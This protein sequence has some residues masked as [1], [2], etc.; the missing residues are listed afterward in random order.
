MVSRLRALSFIHFLYF[1][2][3]YLYPDYGLAAVTEASKIP[4]KEICR[5]G[6]VSPTD[7]MDWVYD[8]FGVKRKCTGTDPNRQIAL[9]T[10]PD[11]DTKLCA[12]ILQAQNLTGL[13]ISQSSKSYS[14]ARVT[15]DTPANR[16]LFLRGKLSVQCVVVAPAEGE[17]NSEKVPGAKS[18]LIQDSLP[19][20]FQLRIRDSQDNLRHDQGTAGFKKAG[21]AKFSIDRDTLAGTTE[22]YTKGVIGLDTG[23]RF[24]GDHTF[25]LTPYFTGERKTNT[26]PGTSGDIDKIGGGLIADFDY[27]PRN[28]PLHFGLSIDPQFLTDSIGKTRIWGGNLRL[29]PAVIFPGNNI[30]PGGRRTVGPITYDLDL[31]FLG[32][33]SNVVDNGGRP[34]LSLSTNYAYGGP[35][36][37]L[38][39]AGADDTWLDRF[40]MAFSYYNLY[41]YTGTY[42]RIEMF[43][44]ELKYALDTAG[45]F[46]LAL[47]YENGRDV[48]QFVKREGWNLTLTYKY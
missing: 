44:A 30:F 3:A 7:Y 27:S 28:S 15:P 12:G 43:T 8:N 11:V 36:F 10:D 37:K 1:V 38:A 40:T 39:L 13:L 25:R 2:L 41:R 16:A 31:N 9:L 46:Q 47:G 20:P 4:Q 19:L 6:K 29:E 5:D 14:P 22:Y 33:Y 34:E 48:E 45:L 32:R 17:G 21:G 24:I 42:D 18:A 26:N 35:E 23:E